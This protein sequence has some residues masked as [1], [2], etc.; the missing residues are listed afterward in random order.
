[1]IHGDALYFRKPE[2]MPAETPEQQDRLIALALI[3]FA[4]GHV[5]ISAAILARGEIARRV[6]AIASIDAEGLTAELGAWHARRR[7]K[8]LRS[9]A[10][11]GLRGL[12]R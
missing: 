3:A 8:Q 7:R 6:R 10:L 5:D 11:T 1:L 2:A 9:A 4:Y 12:I